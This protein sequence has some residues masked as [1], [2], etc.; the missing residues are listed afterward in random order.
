MLVLFVIAWGWILVTVSMLVWYHQGV[1][2][3]LPVVIRS[4]LPASPVAAAVG[5]S[6]KDERR[7][8][9]NHRPMI[10]P[11]AAA[12]GNPFRHDLMTTTTDS[13]S[14]TVLA[15]L[16]PFTSPLIVFTCK[17]PDYLRQTLDDIYK[18]RETSCRMG[19]PIIISQD[20][21][22]PGVV[23]VIQEYQAVFAEAGI[24]LI[25]LQHEA[26]KTA[27]VRKRWNAYELLALHY[28]WA[29]GQVFGDQLFFQLPD[30]TQ[31]QL[32]ADRLV[33]LE[34]D[35]HIAVDF[36]HYFAALAPI[37]DGDPTLLAVSAFNDNGLQ[38]R[39]ADATRVLRSDFF[40]GLGWMMTRRLWKEELSLKWPRGYWDDWLRE[41][42]Q[43]LG[44]HIL[45]PEISR[46]YH[47]GTQGGASSNQ[48]GGTLSKVQL[49]TEAVD[50]SSFQSD[51][52]IFGHSLLKDV[53]DRQYWSMLLAA[54]QVESVVEAEDSIRNGNSDVRLEYGD[55]SDFA[56]LAG[57][58]GLMTDEKAGVPRTAYKG[59]VETRLDGKH[60]LFLTP[61]M[62]DLRQSFN[63]A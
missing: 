13:D 22:D 57:Q 3:G 25:H 60:F 8:N 32:V 31:K 35:L 23:Q 38:G 27:N 58:L 46:T 37:L 54:K 48:F 21:K 42:D 12:G 26:P 17:R 1:A 5:A 41:P 45:R 62:E 49:N 29:L 19:C 44:R 59:V 4:H 39:V 7:R 24:P 53:F 40:P 51:G 36:F 6:T 10:L 14:S 11:A 56:G 20:G 50:W 2:A 52:D 9:N 61:R 30:G 43:R 16:T 28:G 18:F 47:F 55:L 34:E 63:Q 15:N 33:I